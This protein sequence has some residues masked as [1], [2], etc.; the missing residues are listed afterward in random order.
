MH[1]QVTINAHFSTGLADFYSNLLCVCILNS[2][3]NFNHRMHAADKPFIKRR[4]YIS[5]Y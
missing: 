4:C 2:L 1:L 5:K 3:P